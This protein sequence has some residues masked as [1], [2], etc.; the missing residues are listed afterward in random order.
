VLDQAVSSGTNFS[1]TVLVAHVSSAPEFGAFALI[2]TVGVTFVSIA[3][4]IAGEPLA[5]RFAIP[6]RQLQHVASRGAAAVAVAVGILAGSSSVIVALTFDQH[7]WAFPL[8]ALSVVLPGVLLQDFVRSVYIVVES[9][10]RGAFLNDTAWAILMALGCALLLVHGDASPA[11]FVLVW[12]LT[13]SACGVMGCCFLR[14][15]PSVTRIRWWLRETRDLWPFFL[16]DNALLWVSVVAMSSVVALNAGLGEVAG[17]RAMTTLFGPIIVLSLAVSL[18]AVPELAKRSDLRGKR[19]QRVSLMIGGT[20]GFVTALI[21]AAVWFIPDDV[22]RRVL[23]ETWNYAHPLIPFATIDAVGAMLISGCVIGLRSQGRGRALLG[24]RVV[25]SLG[26][27]VVG[28]VGAVLNG[29]LG[30]MGL[31]ALSAP[32]NVGIWFRPL[33]ALSQRQEREM[34]VVVPPSS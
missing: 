22:G 29:A 2:M 5:A 23:G 9:S 20:L 13:G 28:S 27:L 15:S 31:L 32:V 16:S 25:T 4:G 26:R 1:V 17:M 3:R 6:D 10:P 8:L 11:H 24:A 30:A 34:V 33:H 14:L 12:G 18:F 21:G 7:A 19:L